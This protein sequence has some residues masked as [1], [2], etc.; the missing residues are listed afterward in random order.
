[1][2]LVSSSKNR[3]KIPAEDCH[4]HE[5]DTPLWLSIKH[6]TSTNQLTYFSIN[7]TKVKQ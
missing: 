7:F 3:A 4:F 2:Q 5:N 1:M 6:Y